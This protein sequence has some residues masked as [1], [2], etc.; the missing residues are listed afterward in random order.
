M[1]EGL[2]NTKGKVTQVHAYLHSRTYNE[3]N[4]NMPSNDIN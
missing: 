2:A 3:Y 4:Q 1:G